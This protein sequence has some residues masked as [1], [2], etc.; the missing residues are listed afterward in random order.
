VTKPVAAFRSG[1]ISD[2]RHTARLD[3][4]SHWCYFPLSAGISLHLAFIWAISHIT[5]SPQKGQ[6][7]TLC[8]S[9]RIRGL[10]KNGKGFI[11]ALFGERA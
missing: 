8:I 5:P 9:P 4:N 2:S 6:Q 1:V 11:V 7:K 3:E 10:E